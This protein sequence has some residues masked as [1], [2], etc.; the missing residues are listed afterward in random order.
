[1]LIDRDKRTDLLP[2]S[3]PNAPYLHVFYIKFGFL[4]NHVPMVESAFGCS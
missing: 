2:Q 1:M 4:Y 3:L